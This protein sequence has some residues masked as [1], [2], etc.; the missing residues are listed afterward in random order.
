ML[1]TDMAVGEEIDWS[2]IDSPTQTKPRETKS[3]KPAHE[4]PTKMANGKWECNHKCK[5]KAV[6]APPHSIRIKLKNQLQ[7]PLL[8]RRAR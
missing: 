6:Y 5:D 4:E 3:A 2:I 7:A 1:N 8:S